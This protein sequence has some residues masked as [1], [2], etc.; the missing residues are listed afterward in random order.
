MLR[1]VS[2]VGVL[3]F[4][5][6]VYADGSR[7][8]S[9]AELAQWVSEALG[10]NPEILGA[11]QRVRRMRA[12]TP[13]AGALPDP[14]LTSGVINEGRAVP[15]DSLGEADFSEVYV[16]IAQGIPFPGKRG[17]R[18]DVARSEALAENSAYEATRLRVIGDVIQVYYDFHAVKAARE[19]LE[20]N[21]A[22]MDR[23]AR[24]ARERFAVGQ[25]MQQDVLGAELELS[26]LEERRS[27]LAE[28]EELLAASA[29]RLLDRRTP[30]AVG[31]LQPLSATPL[32][33]TE[34]DWLARAERASPL[35]AEQ[36]ARIEAASRRVD[37]ARKERLP[38]FGIQLVYH[39]RG[40]R[41]LDPFYEIGASVTVPL[42]ADRKQQKAVEEAGADLAGTRSG[43]N[44]A[45]AA[46]RYEVSRAFLKA[47]TSDRLLRL[48]AQGLLQQSR[49][50]LDSAIAQ[51]Q[52][53]KVDF[54]SVIA[55]W[56]RLLE[57][58]I[59]YRQQLAAHENALSQLEL[60]SGSSRWVP[61]A[62]LPENQP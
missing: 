62:A 19:T 7:A 8:E 24:V 47:K 20:R 55:S 11:E 1:L 31:T 21:L 6:P 22:L 53:G 51:Y 23:L 60:Q 37:L 4:A 46:L 13:Q 54:E 30:F 52:V 10:R 29:A 49:L 14:T 26:R 28:Q 39:N 17:L 32:V 36:N 57:D 27:M 33:G 34:E 50:V 25:G 59:A 56:R 3:A 61:A 42:Y 12:R 41:D 40:Q 5:A 43:A 44:A 16:G 35:L 58:E 2:I 38:D 45:R 15:F 18:E 48:Y 9:P